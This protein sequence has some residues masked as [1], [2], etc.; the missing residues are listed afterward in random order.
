MQ[1]IQECACWKTTKCDNKDK[2]PTK[3]NPEMPCREN[4]FTQNP[5]PKVFEVCK[6]CTVFAKYNR[7]SD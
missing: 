5:L 3:S 1:K 7:S 4:C 2:C 6:N